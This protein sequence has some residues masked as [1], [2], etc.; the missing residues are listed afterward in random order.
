MHCLPSLIAWW[1]SYLG[2]RLTLDSSLTSSSC[3]TQDVTFFFINFACFMFK[4]RMSGSRSA[5]PLDSPHSTIS[6]SQRVKHG[7]P[8]SPKLLSNQGAPKLLSNHGAPKPLSNLSNG[9]DSGMKRCVHVT[10]RSQNDR[11]SR[12]SRLTRSCPI[13]SPR[14]SYTGLPQGPFKIREVSGK[15]GCTSDFICQIILFLVRF[16]IS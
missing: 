5:W 9:G 15:N 4:G 7:A 2:L 16:I 3:F 14:N 13:C 6:S 8:K 11:L 10:A 12:S 1:V